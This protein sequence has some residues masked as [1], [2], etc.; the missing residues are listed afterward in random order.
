MVLNFIDEFCIILDTAEAQTHKGLENVE[1]YLR[2][3]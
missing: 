1:K 3:I 2:E